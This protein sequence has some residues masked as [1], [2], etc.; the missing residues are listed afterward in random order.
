MKNYRSN[1]QRFWVFF[2]LFLSSAAIAHADVGLMLEQ[3]MGHNGRLT[4]AG[5]VA[6]YLSRV[7]AASP[8]KLRRCRPGENGVVISR[9]HHADQHDWTAIPLVPYLY[10]VDR[11]D[12]IPATADAASVARLREN[13]RKEHLRAFLSAD[14]NDSTHRN[15]IQLAGS[16]YDRKI[17]VFEVKTSAAQ[18]DALIRKLN[19]GENKS[20]FNIV[21]NNCANFAESILNFYYPHSIHRSFTADLGVM[22]P[23]QA[24]RSLASYGKHHRNVRVSVFVIPQ[25][26]G[27]LNRSTNTYGV[28]EAL[29][30]KK[31]YVIPLIPI[32]VL[33]PYFTV[34]LV[35]TYIT[36]GRFNPNRNS[37]MLD[38]KDEIAALSHDAAPGL[39][40]KSAPPHA[41]NVSMKSPP[42]GYATEA[43]SR[44]MEPGRSTVE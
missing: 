37:I 11:P 43:S 14:P 28:I 21:L 36:R 34:A 25:V 31:Q 13:Y 17:Y 15:W 10:A 1:P 8:T 18:D 24:A 4:G 3:P 23:K 39:L 38:R 16:A 5:H 30:K 22:T 6:I 40:Q 12:E 2:L 7:C 32:T 20:H 19:A 9:Y 26:P 44:P 41:Q 29:L 42:P 35:G 33:Q 27:T